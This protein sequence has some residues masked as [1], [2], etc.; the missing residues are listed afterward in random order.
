MMLE[1]HP[2]KLNFYG[3]KLIGVCSQ[4]HLKF[5][6]KLKKKKIQKRK[7][8]IQERKK[9]RKEKHY[10]WFLL[11]FLFCFDFCFDFFCDSFFWFFPCRYPGPD[12]K[13]EEIPNL[14]CRQQR[15]ANI[16]DEW[17]EPW[18]DLMQRAADFEKWLIA[19]P[20]KRICK[21]FFCLLFLLSF[22]FFFLL[23]FRFN[24]ISFFCPFFSIS[25]FS[26]FS[27]L[28]FLY[29]P[30]NFFVFILWLGFFLFFSFNFFFCYFYSF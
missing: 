15:S 21:L 23:L 20:E 22:L 19:R 29:F 17:E 25:L 26:P 18:A 14:T 7:R 28:T 16:K 3:L 11:F 13:P 27:T 24:F 1:I 30:Q 12:Y 9:K 6:G 5:G 8:K 4:I 10:C 2:R